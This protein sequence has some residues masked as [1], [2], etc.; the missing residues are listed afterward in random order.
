[1][2]LRT[3]AFIVGSVLAIGSGL[4]YA[5]PVHPGFIQLSMPVGGASIDLPGIGV[6]S[7]DGK[8]ITGHP[9]N[10]NLT[11][12]LLDIFAAQLDALSNSQ[13]QV[14]A[15]GYIGTAGGKFSA[16]TLGLDTSGFF[17]VFV[18]LNCDF[19]PG[20]LV[21]ESDPLPH[22]TGLMT[23][24]G[25]TGEGGTLDISLDIYADLLFVDAADPTHIIAQRLP[26]FTLTAAHVPWVHTSID[27]FGSYP[28]T[29]LDLPQGISFTSSAS[30]FSG[31]NFLPA[32]IPAAPPVPEPAGIF[33]L[34]AATIILLAAQFNRSRSN[35]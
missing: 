7:L 18:T 22:S 8:S 12:T 21:P 16:A 5:D 1:M 24:H 29:G 30:F 32:D 25:A 9:D 31:P 11:T 26:E 14:A 13:A 6:V 4:A 23:V 33:L 28:T 20:C 2:L 17:D 19:L 15:E 34:G 35:I 3:R 27:S 10:G